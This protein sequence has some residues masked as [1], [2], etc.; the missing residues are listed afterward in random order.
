MTIMLDRCS[1]LKELDLS[2]FDTN[3]VTDMSSMFQYLFVI[4]RIKSY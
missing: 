2:N 3:N 1:S 4:K